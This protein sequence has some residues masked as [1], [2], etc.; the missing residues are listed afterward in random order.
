VERVAFD[1][2]TGFNLD[3]VQVLLDA[4]EPVDRAYISEKSG[5]PTSNVTRKIDDLLILKIIG[6]TKQESDRVG[7]PSVVYSVH[8]AIA[9]LWKK[10]E[11]GRPVEHAKRSVASRPRR[12]LKIKPKKG[13]SQP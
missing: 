11:V 10:A 3:I 2:S 12:R 13:K 6:K 4:G 5:L 7:R 8:P 1:T 9:E